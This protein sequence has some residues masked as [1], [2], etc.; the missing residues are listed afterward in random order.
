M[1]S[2]FIQNEHYFYNDI[3]E[4]NSIEKDI[5]V[6]CWTHTEK[7]NIIKKLSDFTHI[8]VTCKCNP[9]IHELCLNYWINKNMSCPICRTKIFNPKQKY[10]TYYIHFVKYTKY[11]FRILC[12]INLLFHLILFMYMIFENFYI[13]FF[14][15]FTDIY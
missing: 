1:F 10:L 3:N 2:L 13:T 11:S 8:T 4:E 7:D 14:D 12:A 9:K 6:I 15:N 5:C